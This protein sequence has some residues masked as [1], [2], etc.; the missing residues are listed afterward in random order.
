[1][2]SDKLYDGDTMNQKVLSAAQL[3]SLGGKRRVHNDGIMMLDHHYNMR[4]ME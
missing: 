4:E 2:R 1:M 3:P